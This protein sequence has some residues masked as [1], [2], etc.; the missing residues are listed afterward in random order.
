M[1][2]RQ[3][4][5]RLGDY[6]LETSARHRACDRGFKDQQCAFLADTLA[7]IDQVCGVAGKLPLKMCFAAEG[8]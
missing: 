6:F 3:K 2:I 8:L 7:E 4:G 5:P 1:A